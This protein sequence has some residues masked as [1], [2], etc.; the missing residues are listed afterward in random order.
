MMQLWV[1]TW[2]NAGPQ[3]EAIR[4]QEIQ[5][6]DNLAVLATLERAFNHAART[7]PP[8]TSSGLV[9][10]QDWLAKLRR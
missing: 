8:R 2:Q 9:D 5:K 7:I 3:L 6:A 10:M 4:Q 1:Q